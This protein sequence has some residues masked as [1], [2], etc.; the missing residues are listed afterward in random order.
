MLDGEDDAVIYKQCDGKT[1]DKE[2][3]RTGLQ[4]FVVI[5]LVSF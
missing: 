4:R 3:L 1:G 2:G 5:P